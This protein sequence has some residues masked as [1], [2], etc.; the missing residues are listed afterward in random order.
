MLRE[1]I[2]N[3]M[4]K[5]ASKRTNPAKKYRDEINIGTSL[6]S[7]GMSIATSPA[8]LRKA[9]DIHK[10]MKRNRGKLTPEQ[11]RKLKRSRNWKT[12]LGIVS[13]ISGA[14]NAYSGF[15]SLRRLS[16]RSRRK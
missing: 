4:D 15:T 5:L 3:A 16:R 6:P 12:I 10:E 9:Y 1:L 2:I 14:H 7:F 11:I 13:A 8:I